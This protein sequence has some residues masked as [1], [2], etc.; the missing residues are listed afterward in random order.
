MEAKIKSNRLKGEK[1]PY[2]FYFC[3]QC[4]DNSQWYLFDQSF[5]IFRKNLHGNNFKLRKSC[6]NK[7]IAYR[8]PEHPLPRFT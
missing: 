1:R 8:T 3:L 2:R 5:F 4:S 7:N 6:S